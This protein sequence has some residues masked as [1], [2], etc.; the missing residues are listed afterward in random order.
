M[1][2]ST[3]A[4]AKSH[5]ELKTTPAKPRVE[6]LDAA[7]GLAILSVIICHGI[8]FYP[9]NVNWVFTFHVPLFFYYIGIFL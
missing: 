5:T 6:Y 9:I 2:V 8:Y 1:S 7:R 4:I 3:A